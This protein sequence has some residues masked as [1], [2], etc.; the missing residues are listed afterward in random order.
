MP[1]L[2]KTP[3]NFSR[4]VKALLTKIGKDKTMKKEKLISSFKEDIIGNGG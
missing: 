3:W 2:H 1:I 4:K